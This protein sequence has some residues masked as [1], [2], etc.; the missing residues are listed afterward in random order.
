MIEPVMKVKVRQ[1]TEEADD[2]DRHRALR[3]G[4]GVLGREAY[5]MRGD[6]LSR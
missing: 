5:L 6:A 2:V 1:L 3:Y 4:E